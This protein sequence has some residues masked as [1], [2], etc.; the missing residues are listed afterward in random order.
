[1]G[2]QVQQQQAPQQMVAWATPYGTISATGLASY[3]VLAGAGANAV[4]QLASTLSGPALVGLGAG[5]A[6]GTAVAAVARH[7]QVT[8]T[9]LAVKHMDVVDARC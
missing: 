2:M 6:A 4:Y 8:Y 7:H 1:M 9:K 5:A 3:G